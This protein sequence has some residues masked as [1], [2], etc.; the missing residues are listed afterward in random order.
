[1]IR[2]FKYSEILKK[3]I[4]SPYLRKLFPTIY[5]P[6]FQVLNKTRKTEKYTKLLRI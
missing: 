6:L 2:F 5:F 4:E 3:R 1:M